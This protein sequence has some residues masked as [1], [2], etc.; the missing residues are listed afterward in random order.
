MRSA[1]IAL[2]LALAAAACTP[3]P[4]GEPSDAVR[5]FYRAVDEGSCATMWTHIASEYRLRLERE[6]ASCEVILEQVSAYPLERVL[7]T[8]ADGRDG[9][10][11]LVRA[12]LRGRE[13]DVIFRVEAEDGQWKLMA[14]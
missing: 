14:L 9:D 3:S 7:D 13:Q 10:A 2:S 12:R 5:D 4:K 6:G 11:R 8:R 1:V